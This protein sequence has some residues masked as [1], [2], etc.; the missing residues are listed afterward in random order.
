[1]IC[2]FLPI[3]KAKREFRKKCI[4]HFPYLQNIVLRISLCLINKCGPSIEIQVIRG[5]DIPQPSLFR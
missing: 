4:I 5:N 1:M 2:I 3:T